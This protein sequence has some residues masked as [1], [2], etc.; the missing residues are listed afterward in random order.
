[1][2]GLKLFRRKIWASHLQ[3]HGCSVHRTRP[4]QSKVKPFWNAIKWAQLP[5]TEGQLPQEPPHFLAQ[6][7]KGIPFLSPGGNLPHTSTNCCPKAKLKTLLHHQNSIFNVRKITVRLVGAYY[8]WKFLMPFNTSSWAPKLHA[9]GQSL[10]DSC[11][12]LDLITSWKYHVFSG[13][14]WGFTSISFH[15]LKLCFLLQASHWG[16]CK[17]KR[18]TSSFSEWLAAHTRDHLW[19]HLPFMPSPGSWR[20]RW[21]GEGAVGNVHGWLMASQ[22]KF[23]PFKPQQKCSQTVTHMRVFNPTHPFSSIS[24]SPF[25]H[26]D[27]AV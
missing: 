26:V 20:L 17:T 1:M 25:N 27:I 5:I 22:T 16:S 2:L 4:E 3:E 14:W 9:Q 21:E 18:E 15:H 12:E 7:Q 6:T 24:S 13:W 11:T 23:Q 10:S 8:R 19:P